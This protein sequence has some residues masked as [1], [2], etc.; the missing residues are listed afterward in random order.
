[1]PKSSLLPHDF[2]WYTRTFRES[3][4]VSRS[5]PLP[6][7]PSLPLFF[8]TPRYAVPQNVEGAEYSRDALAKALYARLF[9]WI[10]EKVNIA[11][12]FS[13]T[14]DALQIGVLDIYGMINFILN[15]I[16]LF[17][18]LLCLFLCYF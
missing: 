9:D 3:Q 14:H 16:Y 10:V 17:I 11:L 4:H 13:P 8:Y 7:S 1:M 18:F 15:F 12:G 6:P 2:H 5:P